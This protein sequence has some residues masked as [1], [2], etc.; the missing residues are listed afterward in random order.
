MQAGAVPL[1]EKELLKMRYWDRNEIIT[2]F[3]FTDR[4]VRHI[5]KHWNETIF[6]T[7]LKRV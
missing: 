2:V 5:V 4:T 3:L 1:V 7:F 6:K